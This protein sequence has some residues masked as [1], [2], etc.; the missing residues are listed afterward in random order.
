MRLGE[1]GAAMLGVILVVSILL[2]GVPAPGP[3]QSSAIELTPIGASST[4]LTLAWATSFVPSADLRLADNGTTELLAPAST[5]TTTVG[6]LRPVTDYAFELAALA[7]NGTWVSAGTQARTAA[8]GFTA[9]FSPLESASVSLPGWSGGLRTLDDRTY[10]DDVIAESGST[11]DYV[12]ASQ[13]L[14]RYDAGRVTLLHA[15]YLFVNGSSVNQAVAGTN[16]PSGQLSALWSVGALSSSGTDVTFQIYWTNGT[17]ELV[18]TGLSA[19]DA[20]VAGAGLLGTS[21]WVYFDRSPLNGSSASSETLEFYNITTGQVLTSTIDAAFNSVTYVPALDAVVQDWNNGTVDQWEV[22]SVS[23]GAVEHI[24]VR[25]PTDSQLTGN[26]TN[27]E[28]YFYTTYPNGTTEVWGIGADSLNPPSYHV[29]TLWSDPTLHA[30]PLTET[31]ALGTTDSGA[32]AMYDPTDYA[33][34]GASCLGGADEAPLV[35]PLN[36]SEIY[37]TNISLDDLLAGPNPAGGGCLIT[38]GWEYFGLAPFSGMIAVLGVVTY[39][40]D[41]AVQ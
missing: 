39:Y 25:S 12:N 1:A 23:N 41:P 16:G 4:T 29:T 17:Y 7:P 13:E 15:W 34:N 22:W 20:N 30:G 26:D 18:S 40:W 8:P 27:N 36:H 14:V 10:V 33:L 32:Y 28:P 38:N 19:A 11:Y 9:T 6:D 35:D 2:P 3:A 21:G 5:G 37:A 24:A 31:G